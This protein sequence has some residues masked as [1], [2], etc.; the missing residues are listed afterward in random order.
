MRILISFAL[1]AIVTLFPASVQAAA[2]RVLQARSAWTV[3]RSDENCALVREFGD[4][5][6]LRLQIASFGP[7]TSFSFL[8]S[9][10]LVPYTSD[11]TTWIGLAYSGDTAARD[12]FEVN[13]GR[14]GSATFVSFPARFFPAPDQVDPALRAPGE[15]TPEQRAAI[16]RL[17]TE[18]ADRTTH[19]TVDFGRG[20]LQLE[21]GSMAQP[22]AD[23]R[24]CVDGLI[25]GWGVDPASYRTESRGTSPLPDTMAKVWEV[26]S[27]TR[28]RRE[29]AVYL[30]AR[31]AV[32]EAGQ[33]S[34]CVVQTRIVSETFDSRL[35][36]SLLGPYAP[37]L[38]ANGLP[39]SSL[40]F[41]TISWSNR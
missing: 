6:D 20:P 31:V 26:L 18:F 21:T 29:G 28:V 33:P 5:G 25:A 8:I 14:L 11:P 19:I 41:L 17:A 2:P 38:D 10:K 32:D 40:Y 7:S 16:Q 3:A 9:G 35:C 15:K 36:A 13:R 34:Q 37:A 1:V 22:L 27:V 23:L 24:A 30:A 39:V 12:K 4:E